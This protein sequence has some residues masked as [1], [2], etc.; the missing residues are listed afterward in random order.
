MAPMGAEPAFRISATARRRQALV[1][2]EVAMLI[3]NFV[4]STPG[5]RTGTQT[6]AG[7]PLAACNINGLGE[8]WLSPFL[9]TN[10]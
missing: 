2:K 1:S 7:D 8:G 9:G 5:H 3:I 4:L 10:R 6:S